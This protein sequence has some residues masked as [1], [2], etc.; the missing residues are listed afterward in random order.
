MSGKWR[1]MMTKHTIND[2]RNHAD[3]EPYYEARIDALKARIR[4]LTEEL[5][6]KDKAIAD[7]IVREA[8]ERWAKEALIAGA[9]HD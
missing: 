1:L 7:A 3:I 9:A 2:N 8:L 4:E 5:N 6:R